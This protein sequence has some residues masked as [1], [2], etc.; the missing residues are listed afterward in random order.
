MKFFFATNT[1]QGVY[2]WNLWYIGCPHK[3]QNE[4]SQGSK[5]EVPWP[6]SY[7][8]KIKSKYF[9][10]IKERVAKKVHGWKEENLSRV[11]REVLI[12]VRVQSI[13][14]YAMTLLLNA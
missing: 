9:N 8:W 7:G 2:A 11:E 4:K 1:T 6:T 12:K 14:T 3:A 5:W 10:G 13:P